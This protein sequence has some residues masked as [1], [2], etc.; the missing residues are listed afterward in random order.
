M[1]IMVI[2]IKTKVRWFIMKRKMKQPRCISSSTV[3]EHC[4]TKPFQ[5]AEVTGHLHRSNTSLERT[6]DKSR[7]FKDK[8]T[9]NYTSFSLIYKIFD[10]FLSV[11]FV[12]SITKSH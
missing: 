8:S 10:T 9:H 4:K 1:T 3:A 6:K 11:I 5:G 7:L 2:V 12:C